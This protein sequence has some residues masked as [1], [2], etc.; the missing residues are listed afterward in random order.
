MQNAK[1][2]VPLKYLSNFFRSLEMS[3]INCKIYLELNWNNNCAMYGADANTGGDDRKTTFKI[4]STNLYVPIVTLSTKINVNLTK[5]L[6]EGFKNSVYSNEYISKIET[7]TADKKN[8]ER[9]LLDAS[10]QEVNRLFVLAFNNTTEND[11]E[12]PA[13][14]IDNR[15]QR[16]SRGKYFLPRVDIINYNVLIDGRNVYDQPISNHIKMYDEI[17]KIGTEKGDDYTAG[18][19]LDYQYFKD[20]YQLVA[21]D[22]L[23]QKE[24]DAN[25]RAIHQIE[26]HGMLTLDSHLPKKFALFASLKAL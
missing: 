5:Q 6:N 26:F 11:A 16:D 4:K 21:V 15:V 14:N 18:C 23:K 10:F 24:L 22:L 17:R 1:I 9:F 13:R 19:L 7:K 3:L 12:T 20:N 2:G 8:L 25:P